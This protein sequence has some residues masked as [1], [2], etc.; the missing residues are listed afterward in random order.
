MKGS[1]FFLLL[2]FMGLIGCVSA[3]PEIPEEEHSPRLGISQNS[4]GKVTM[5]WE[6]D[7]R[8]FYTIYCRDGSGTWKEHRSVRQVRGTGGTMTAV[9]RVDPRRPARR[10]RLHFEKPQDI[11]SF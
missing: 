11:R 2:L 5:S 10:Y 4:A 6:S 7:I 1:P 9:D 3:P 8:Y